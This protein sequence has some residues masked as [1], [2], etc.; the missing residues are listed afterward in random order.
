MARIW[1]VKEGEVQ[2][3][4]AGRGVDKS[5]NWCVQNFHLRSTR[6]RAGPETRGHVLR[7]RRD[8][9]TIAGKTC[10]PTMNLIFGERSD[11]PIQLPTLVVVCVDDAELVRTCYKDWQPGFYV[12]DMDVQEAEQLLSG[13][14]KDDQSG[15]H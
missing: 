9:H 3:E 8:D 7:P 5:F 11:L 14:I 6:W 4:N 1:F 10:D 2:R 15:T 12:P 13:T